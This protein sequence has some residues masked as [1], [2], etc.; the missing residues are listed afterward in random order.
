MKNRLRAFWDELR[1]SY[2]FIPSVMAVMS[3]ALSIATIRL[4]EGVGR[5]LRWVT[6]LVY[7]DSAE[8]AREVLSTVAS[9]MITVAGVVFSLTMVVLSLTSQQYGPLVLSH[10]MRDRGNQFVLGVFIATFLYCLLV[11]RTVRGV[12]EDIFVPHIS[13][14]TG[15]GLAI[16]SLAVLIYFIHHVSRSIQAP[17][18][19]AR[20]RDELMKEIEDQFPTQVG[21]KNASSHPFGDRME[22]AVFQRM[23]QEASVVNTHASGY[24]QRID[25][26]VLLQTARSSDLIVQLEVLPGQFLFQGQPLA[27]IL[28]SGSQA[29][30]VDDAIQGAFILGDQRTQA[31]DIEFIVTQLSAIAVRS[32]SP[33]LNDPYTA[34]MVIDHLADAL[35]SVLHRPPPSVYRYDEDNRLRVI[36]HRVTFETLFH[37]AFD[38]IRH[39][40]HGDSKID[41]RLLQVFKVLWDCSEEEDTKDLLYHY[42]TQLYEESKEKLTD[43]E[44]DRV[45]RVYAK[46]L[47]EFSR[48]EEG[49]A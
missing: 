11:L 35:C 16:A 17:N 29:E 7:V 18:I 15:L 39:Y 37:T 3:V 47:H 38:Q 27:R 22:E 30:A 41:I 6:G 45:G 5:E 46:V 26:K 23:A 48:Q 31:Q 49:G 9:S 32:L 2:W 10:F 13:V 43:S 12:E 24:L 1:A 21:I 34:L 8:G 19:I 20:I 25:D 4:D 28:V 40:G 36:T 42:A 44:D 14:L 33:S